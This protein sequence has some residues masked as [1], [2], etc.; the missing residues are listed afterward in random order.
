MEISSRYGGGGHSPF[1][2]CRMFRA[3]RSGCMGWRHVTGCA[4]LC[5]YAITAAFVWGASLCAA[6]PQAEAR[7]N[8]ARDAFHLFAL[9][10]CWPGTN[11]TERGKL[12][13]RAAVDSIRP[14]FPDIPVERWSEIEKD[15]EPQ[16]VEVFTNLASEVCRK[17]FTH[18]ELRELIEFFESPLGQKYAAAYA[19]MVQELREGDRARRAVFDEIVRRLKAPTRAPEAGQPDAPAIRPPKSRTTEPDGPANGSQPVRS[20]TNSTSSAAGSRR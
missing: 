2:H 6:E 18:Q 8:Y 17:R 19:P 12:L 20:E 10:E 5:R 4:A 15:F 11:F 14:R 3:A 1:G 16:I 9:L 7:S 13:T